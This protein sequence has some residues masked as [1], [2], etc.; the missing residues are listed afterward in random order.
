MMESNLFNI[1]TVSLGSIR[2]HHLIILLILIAYLWAEEKK[3][4]QI[5]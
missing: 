4:K 3:V 5:N 1:T 2:Y